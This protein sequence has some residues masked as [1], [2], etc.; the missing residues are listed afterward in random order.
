MGIPHRALLALRDAELGQ[1]KRY[2]TL[3]IQGCA[4]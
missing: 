3:G 2:E 1:N 4:D